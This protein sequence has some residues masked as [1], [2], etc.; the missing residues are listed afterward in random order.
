M[1]IVQSPCSTRYRDRYGGV[2]GTAIKAQRSPTI[3][4][5]DLDGRSGDL[6]AFSDSLKVKGGSLS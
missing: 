3:K 5:A 2:S 6:K 4:N 1:C